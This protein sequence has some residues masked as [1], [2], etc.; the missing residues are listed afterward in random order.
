MRILWQ[1]YPLAAK[2]VIHCLE[3]ETYWSPRTT[4][5][6]IRRLV[7][8]GALGFKKEGRVYFYHPLISEDRCQVAETESF[9]NRVFGGSI[10]PLVFQ[11][12]KSHQLSRNEVQQLRY[13]LDDYSN[14]TRGQVQQGEA[15]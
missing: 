15:S 10:Y 8:K 1:R 13:L 2:E 14:R 12:M 9:L 3:Q 7:K 5:T 6:L 11:F 4:K